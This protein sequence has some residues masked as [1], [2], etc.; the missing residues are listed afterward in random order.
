MKLG[1]WKCVMELPSRVFVAN[2]SAFSLE[3]K[4]NGCTNLSCVICVV[5]IKEIYMKRSIF[6]VFRSFESIK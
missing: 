3:S 4:G 6:N 1:K 5:K 2:I